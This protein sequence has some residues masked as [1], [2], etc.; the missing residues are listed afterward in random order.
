MTTELITEMS[1]FVNKYG[2]ENT[3]THLMVQAI[4]ELRH[5][6]AENEALRAQ[7]DAMSKPQEPVAY[8]A[9]HHAFRV[10]PHGQDAE[11]HDWLEMSDANDPRAFPVYSTPAP[12]RPAVAE[13]SDEQLV[14]I[15][16][17]KPSNMPPWGIGSTRNDYLRAVRSVL[18]AA[19]PQAERCT[20]CDGTGDVIDM[21]GE[22]LGY[23][24]CEEGRALKAEKGGA[25]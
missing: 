5:L 16:R 20:S 3:A 1:E 4:Q 11:G 15:G 18:L 10:S 25:R 9:E 19:A 21:T 14:N 22:W 23:C 8:L 13:F 24:V 7:V 17:H 6:Q 2:G 12:T